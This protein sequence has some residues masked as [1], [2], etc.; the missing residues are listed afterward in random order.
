MGGDAFQVLLTNQAHAGVQYAGTVDDHGDGTY[1]ARYTVATAGTYALSV[2]LQTSTGV[3]ELLN[4]CVAA[5]APFIYSRVYNGVTPYAAPA[6]CAST[7]KP[8]V[9]VVHSEFDA[10]SSTYDEGPA[11]ALTNAVVGVANSFTVTSRDQFGNPR[12]GDNTTHFAGYGNGVSDSFV[13]TFT[14]AQTGDVVTVSSA[15]DHIVAANV[16][17]SLGSPGNPMQVTLYPPSGPLSFNPAS[18]DTL[19]PRVSSCSTSVCRWAGA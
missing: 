15:I 1:T 13:A 8:L 6:F 10:P 11:L 17:T 19:P 16:P 18:S 12:R 5:A 14:Q 9:K 4:T 3:V 2:T 7:R